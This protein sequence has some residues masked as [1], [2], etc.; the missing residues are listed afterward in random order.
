MLLVSIFPAVLKASSKFIM[1]L[2]LLKYNTGSLK[3]DLF[4]DS[5]EGIAGTSVNIFWGSC[6]PCSKLP[7]SQQAGQPADD[8]QSTDEAASINDILKLL[9]NNFGSTS[10][11]TLDTADLKSFTTVFF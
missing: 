8:L 5:F 4:V 9:A 6:D 7:V 11:G 2:H 10:I 1:I 3:V